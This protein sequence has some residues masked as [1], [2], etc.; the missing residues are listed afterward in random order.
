MGSTKQPCQDIAR[1]ESMPKNGKV[2]S[3]RVRIFSPTNRSIQAVP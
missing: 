3:M 1:N 2:I